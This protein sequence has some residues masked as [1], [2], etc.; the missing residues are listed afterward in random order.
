MHSRFFKSLVSLLCLVT[1][2]S[3][4]S[5]YAN[6]D[7]ESCKV[8]GDVSM[9]GLGIRLGYYLQWAAAILSVYLAPELVKTLYVTF[10]GVS[11]ASLACVFQNLRSGYFAALEFHII[12]LLTAFLSNSAFRWSPVATVVDQLNM[13]SPSTILTGPKSPKVRRSFWAAGSFLRLSSAMAMISVPYM[14]WRG[15]YIGHKEGC[16]VHIIVTI[17]AYTWT[18]NIYDPKWIIAIKVLGMIPAL[19]GAVEIVLN[20]ALI[21]YSALVRI[22]GGEP[23]YSD[24]CEKITYTSI[25]LV[26]GGLIIGHVEGA[27]LGNQVDLS[28]GTLDSSGQLI[29]LLIGALTLLLVILSYLRWLAGQFAPIPSIAKAMDAMSTWL[30]GRI[31]IQR[32]DKAV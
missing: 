22:T 26:T 18:P 25:Q 16:K 30:K 17:V 31:L 10:A 2:V 29:P 9:Y 13:S 32:W 15:N 4:G 20:M 1:T 7:P 24:T 8:I 12:L 21:F 5:Y 19:L 23:D 11:I 3:A 28:K 6:D 14:Y 27:V